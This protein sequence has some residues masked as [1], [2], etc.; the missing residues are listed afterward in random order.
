MEQGVLYIS[1]MYS[2]PG[3]LYCCGCG[4]GVVATLSAAQWSFT[5]DSENVSLTPSVGRRA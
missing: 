5:C 2:T 3:H 1:I 4:Q